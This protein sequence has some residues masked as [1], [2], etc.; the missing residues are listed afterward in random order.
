MPSL[1]KNVFFEN[2]YKKNNV[3]CKKR[4]KNLRNFCFALAFPNF[5]DTI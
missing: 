5:C 3:F 2:K 4:E 1:D